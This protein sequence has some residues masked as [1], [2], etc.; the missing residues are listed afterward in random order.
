MNGEVFMEA[1]ELKQL[2]EVAL[3]IK[4]TRELLSLSVEEMAKNTGKLFEDDFKSSVL[5]L[6]LYTNVPRRLMWTP[7]TF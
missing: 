3:R 1:Q 4:E 2:M 6:H 5:T 7:Q